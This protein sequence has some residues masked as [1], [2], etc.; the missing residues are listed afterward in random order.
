[1][2]AMALALI[3]TR[4]NVCAKT[5]SNAIFAQ[6][7]RQGWVHRDKRLH[8]VVSCELVRKC[9]ADY[10]FVAGWGREINQLLLHGY[11]LD[12]A[13]IRDSLQDTVANEYGRD[14]PP[15]QNC[16]TYCSKVY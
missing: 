6:A 12:P 9:G 16:L 15:R 3:M 10:A 4:S 13:K 8:C 2:C 1:M 14:C 5:I 7:R 11:V